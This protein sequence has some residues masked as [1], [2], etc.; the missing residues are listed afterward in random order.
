[1][2]AHGAADHMNLTID[3]ALLAEVDGS[4][5]ARNAAGELCTHEQVADKAAGARPAPCV[6]VRA[7]AP[8]LLDPEVLRLSHRPPAP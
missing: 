2:N 4:R 1:M 6:A 5:E 7:F 8:P 3:G